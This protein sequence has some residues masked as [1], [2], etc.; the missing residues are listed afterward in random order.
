MSLW[1][2]PDRKAS[3]PTAPPRTQERKRREKPKHDPAVMMAWG[4]IKA[5]VRRQYKN[6]E[7]S[8]KLARVEEALRR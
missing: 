1:A 5:I 7:W 8:E 4:E 2:K 3:P 6:A